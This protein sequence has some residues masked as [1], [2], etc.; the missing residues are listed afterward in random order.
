MT[1][2]KG[3]VVIVGAVPLEFDRDPFYRNE[4]DFLISCSYGPG[5]Y[6]P[7][8]EEQGRDYP[9]A[10]VRWTE[11]R[12]MQALLQMMANGTLRMDQLISAEYPIAEAEQAFAALSTEGGSRPLGIVLK[13]NLTETP[14][15][16]K[17]TPTVSLP[18]ESKLTGRVGLG[19]VGLGG[20]FT[21]MHLPN[22]MAM[23]D[24]Y[25][26]VAT[27]DSKT[28]KAQDIARQTNA[29]LATGSIAE[30][31]TCSDVQLVLIATRHDMHAPLAMAALRAGKHVFVEK[32]V[33]MNRDELAELARVHADSG[34]YYMVG[35]NR[36]FSPHAVRLRELVRDRVKPL[37]INYRVMADPAPLNSWVYSPAGGG[38]VIGEVCHMLDLFNYLVG[39]DIDVAEL[40][41]IATPAGGG[42]PPG[43]SF[44][45][46]LRYADGSVCTLIY[47]TLG[48]KSK[49]NGK[50]RVEALFDGKTYVIDDYVRSLG[51]GCEPGAAANR[52]TKG[53][54]EEL[55]A[56]AE[57]L[58]GRG[59]APLS[60]EAC[61]RAA[62]LSYT[63]D[64][65]CRGGG[66][67]EI[68][69]P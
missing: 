6:D 55:A 37:V 3:R 8:Y 36:R 21:S 50:E 17:L 68:S 19:L 56:L 28:A 49:T 22:I 5:R 46:T 32:P 47:T 20:F 26:V 60:W 35:Y 39:D 16:A 4:I 63:I 58:L 13:Y 52:P 41:I 44:V 59:P 64:A 66:A 33:A 10:Y 18:A 14:N 69:A 34:K 24:R 23:S 12:N 38:R 9:Y 40:D 61:A 2:R 57:Y 27:C 51:T 43:D 42:V 7:T 25:Q 62:E 30:L 45:S 29:R 15:D 48:R 53:H 67:E 54:H 1:R 11:N 65:L 31:L